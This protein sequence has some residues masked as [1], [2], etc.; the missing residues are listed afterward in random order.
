MFAKFTAQM[1]N[2]KRQL[3]V[4]DPD[5][6][7]GP[8]AGRHRSSRYN[9]SSSSRA[10]PGGSSHF[11]HQQRKLIQLQDQGNPKSNACLRI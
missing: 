9:S 1:N 11:S 2:K 8:E 6:E 3:E 10:K 5:Y 7:D 4:G